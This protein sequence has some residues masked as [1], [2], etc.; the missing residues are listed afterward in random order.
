MATRVLLY[1]DVVPDGRWTESGFPEGHANV[2]KLTLEDFQ[3][4]LRHLR[5]AC[6]A[7]VL[8][9]DRANSGWMLTF[10]DG[11]SSAL[12]H[13]GPALDTYGWRAHFFM[14]TGRLGARGFLD[15]P[16]LRALAAQ[17]HLIG[18]HSVTHPLVMSAC[19][20]A[21]LR[22]EWRASIM[23]LADHLGAQPTVASIPGGAYSAAIAEAAAA[24][25]ITQLFT[26]EPTPATWRV[27][28]VTCLGRYTL[29][30]GMKPETAVAFATGQGLWPV[31]QRVEWEAKKVAKALLGPGYQAIR[32]AV[33]P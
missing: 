6:A 11:G 33:M 24:A 9:T 28:D 14:T 2:Y 20:D 30:R 4:H 22:E 29:W 31:R 12:E 3:I 32:R 23:T 7:P 10:D 15:G 17:G 16:G 1:H 19:S 13:I 27:N 25:G 26:S 5:T 18:S 8:I 21:Q